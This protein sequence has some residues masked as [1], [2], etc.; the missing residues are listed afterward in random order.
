MSV[1][2]VGKVPKRCPKCERTYWK[3]YR[4]EANKQKREW[5][6]Q[7]GDVPMRQKHTGPF[8]LGPERPELG[9]TSKEFSAWKARRAV[10]LYVREPDLNME[11][12]AERVGLS[13]SEV[14]RL[15]T[16]AD[17]E[18]HSRVQQFLPFGLPA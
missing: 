7:H 4:R 13:D 10:E 18:R 14:Q 6:K 8:A 11:L 2:K 3:A 5:K 9:M 15:V 16:E 17:I 1:K 12:I